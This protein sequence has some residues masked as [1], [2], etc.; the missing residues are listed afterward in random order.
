VARNLGKSQLGKRIKKERGPREQAS[1]RD[2]IYE[3]GGKGLSQS[4]MTLS[5]RGLRKKCISIR[6]YTRG[7]AFQGYRHDAWEKKSDGECPLEEVIVPY[8]HV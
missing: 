5:G 7:R 4:Q 8:V 3:S 1:T 2:T 6:K